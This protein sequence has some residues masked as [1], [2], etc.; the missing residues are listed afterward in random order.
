MVLTFESGSEILKCDHLDESCW[1]ILYCATVWNGIQ[2]N[3]NF[4]F[5]VCTKTF[6]KFSWYIHRFFIFT[7]KVIMNGWF[8]N[9]F[10]Y[11]QIAE[12]TSVD[13]E[14]PVRFTQEVGFSVEKYEI[15]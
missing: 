12:I 6:Q 7:L 11:L 10:F 2:C 8:N 5:W 9:T 4:Y 15:V 1:A 3:Y 13:E 14:K